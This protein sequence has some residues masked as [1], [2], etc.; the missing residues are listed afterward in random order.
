MSVP[1][2]IDIN[3]Y[4]SKFKHP[5]FSSTIKI[6]SDM[7]IRSYN[8]LYHTFILPI[9]G[10]YS[11]NFVLQSDYILKG[12]NGQFIS[13]DCLGNYLDTVTLNLHNRSKTLSH[14]D[15]FQTTDKLST[16]TSKDKSVI[17]LDFLNLP[18]L[19]KCTDEGT[20]LINIK[21]KQVP[22][23]NYFLAYDVMF[24][25]DPNYVD[26]VNREQFRIYYMSQ[27]SQKTAR[28]VVLAYD[29]GKV[30]LN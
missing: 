13:V 11:H 5:S 22:P 9:V 23:I 2:T 21:F 14:I 20:F 28:Q 16:L 29:K 24:T 26:M 8:E 18:I 12:Y 7:A 25:D 15:A 17:K 10:D 6:Q 19:T 3:N 4:Y 1:H 30:V 27:Q